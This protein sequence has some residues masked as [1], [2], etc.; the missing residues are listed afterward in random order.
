RRVPL[1]GRRVHHDHLEGAGR[2]AVQA[3]GAAVVV[4][5]YQPVAQ[6]RDRP[7]LVAG[8][9][10][11]GV[12]AVDTGQGHFPLAEVQLRVAPLEPGDVGVPVAAGGHTLVATGAEVHVDAQQVGGQQE[13]GGDLL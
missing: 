8:G 6:E 4:D 2:H 13:L 9:L 10:A 5:V 11:G 3:A 7:L 12:Q 1:P